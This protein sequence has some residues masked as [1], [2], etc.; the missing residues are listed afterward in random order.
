MK[1][2]LKTAIVENETDEL[3]KL[4]KLLDGRKDI[5]DV[6]EACAEYALATEL[7]KLRP[8]D[9]CIFDIVLDEGQDCY[10]LI[11]TVGR[12]KLGILGLTTQFPT[13]PS[14]KAYVNIGRCLP[15]EKP[16]RQEN[17]DAFI[18][19][20]TKEVKEIQNLKIYDIPAVG[21]KIIPLR[22]DK[23]CFIAGKGKQ[24]LYYVV[25]SYLNDY[26]V[27]SSPETMEQAFNRLSKDF[28]VQIH[29]S[30]IFNIGFY[31]SRSSGRILHL[32]TSVL[33]NTGIPSKV[34]IKCG[35][36]YLPD[37]LKKLGIE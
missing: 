27:I 33:I 3:K 19:L 14:K 28:F 12:E 18:E 2:P 7:L 13:I 9:L 10:D 5:F 34:K 30:I 15:F 16:Y 4:K 22:Q 23:I 25:D 29:R 11:A 32:K 24:T 17:L 1:F 36:K 35:K 21:N 26:R 6:Q 31:L 37:L 20:L 8:F